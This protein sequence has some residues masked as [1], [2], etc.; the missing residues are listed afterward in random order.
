MMERDCW[1]SDVLREAGR[2]CVES[3]PG[4]MDF[5]FVPGSIVGHV[6]NSR[7]VNKSA[8]CML[9]RQDWR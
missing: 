2:I 7:A 9:S 1:A 5:W 6:A 4:A 3:V 8:G